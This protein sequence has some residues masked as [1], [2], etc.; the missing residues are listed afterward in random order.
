MRSMSAVACPAFAQR[1]ALLVLLSTLALPLLAQQPPIERQMTPE[2][3][4]AAGLDKLSAE[5]LARLNTWLGRTITTET[6]KAAAVAK[7]K[8]EDDNRGFLNFGSD[9]PIQS[10]LAGEFR[11]FGDGRT[12]KLENGQV[13]EQI[14]AAR[15][16]GVSGANLEVTIR[17]SRLGNTWYMRIKG[18]NTAAKVKRV[19]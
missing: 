16:D 10:R 3:F 17:P 8:V 9:T 13:W 6:T 18:Y 5:E 19:K 4:R 14:D 2:E 7:Q 15:L 12:F 11:G 1:V